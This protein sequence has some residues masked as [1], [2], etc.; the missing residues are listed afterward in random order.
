MTKINTDFPKFY[1]CKYGAFYEGQKVAQYCRSGGQNY[2]Y[3][4]TV[5]I[6]KFI[7][8]YCDYL[9]YLHVRFRELHTKRTW[10]LPC[11]GYLGIYYRKIK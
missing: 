3:S 2:Y 6:D 11:E 4:S 1:I 8:H 7:V 10:T 9:P 5:I